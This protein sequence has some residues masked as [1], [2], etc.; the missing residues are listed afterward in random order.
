MAEEAEDDEVRFLGRTRGGISEMPRGAFAPAGARAGEV[1]TLD[2]TADE[3]D[4]E[5]GRVLA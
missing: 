3:G 2:V 1:N 5:R 4:G